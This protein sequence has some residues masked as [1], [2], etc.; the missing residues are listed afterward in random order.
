MRQLFIKLVDKGY[1]IHNK[2]IL[3][4]PL[5]TSQ[6]ARN[7]DILQEIGLLNVW[8]ESQEIFIHIEHGGK[9]NGVYK[10]DVVV[11]GKLLFSKRGFKTTQSAY[12]AGLEYIVNKLD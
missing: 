6:E 1:K 8:L 12:L 11:W 5:F 10:F 2:R 4:N 7:R 3:G 9:N